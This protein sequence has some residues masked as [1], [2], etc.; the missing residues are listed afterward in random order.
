MHLP[1]KFLIVAAKGKKEDIFEKSLLN[2]FAKTISSFLSTL[3]FRRFFIKKGIEEERLLATKLMLNAT[4]LSLTAAVFTVNTQKLKSK[5]ELI[6][7]KKFS[8]IIKNQ[9]K[10]CDNTK[11]KGEKSRFLR[12]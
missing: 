3:Y 11:N 4:L 2:L 12:I 8:K 10:V 7:M 1:Y 5:K 9:L 6:Y